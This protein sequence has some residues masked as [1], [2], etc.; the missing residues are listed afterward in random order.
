[1]RFL[2]RTDPGLP[3]RAVR[4]CLAGLG[5]WLLGLALAGAQEEPASLQLGSNYRIR[6]NDVL[7]MSVYQE[8]DLRSEVRVSAEGVVSLPLI[9]KV[10]A[11]GKTVE[12]LTDELVELYDRDY[13]VNPHVSLQVAGYAERRIQILGQVNRPGI[14]PMPPEE[15]LRLVEAIARAGG[16]T[17]RAD[18][19]SI[20]IRRAGGPDSEP[21]VLTVNVSAVLDN[22]PKAT[23]FELTDGDTVIVGERL[24]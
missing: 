2:K 18:Q 19:R 12:V 24:F 20:Q 3:G 17:R 1:M 5:G 16:F 9:G 4:L 22:D 8:P 15:T 14:V 10:K 6:P 7:V 11:S 23:D 21:M 13:L